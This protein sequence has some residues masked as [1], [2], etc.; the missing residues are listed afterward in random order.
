MIDPEHIEINGAVK[1]ISGVAL[2]D[3][4]RHTFGLRE[5][6]LTCLVRVL[7]SGRYIG[8]HELEAFEQAFA[9]AFGLGYC[10]GVANGTDALE[11][12]L[13]ALGIGTGDRVATVANAGMYATTAILNLGAMPVYVDVDRHTLTMCPASL[14]KSLVPGTKAVVV[15]HLY[16]R[17]ASLPEIVDIVERAGIALVEDCAQAHGAKLD[18]RFAGSWGHAGCFSFYPTKNLGAL[19]DGGA[20]VTSEA[21]LADKLRCLRQYGWRTKYHS[22][23]RGG[24]NSRLDELQAAVLRTMLPHLAVWNARRRGIADRYNKA[25]SGLSLI[26]PDVSD[27]SYVAHLYAVRCRNRD[28]FQETLAQHGVMTDVH[29]PVPDY[30][31]PSVRPLLD[32]SWRL[33]VTEEVCDTIV[34]L[35]CYPELD[36]HEV[37]R[38]IGAVRAALQGS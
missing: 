1:G 15:T 3:L 16:G 14:A 34:S 18:G 8:G 12:A 31:Q 4:K 32:Q 28:T 27:E 2:Q 37:E 5:E 7:D 30:R 33:P 13:R 35:P 21:E 6:L 20:V 29:F 11:L 17:M 24:R 38:V 36:D 19:G 9:V 10:V 25:L 23:I 26:V 22:E